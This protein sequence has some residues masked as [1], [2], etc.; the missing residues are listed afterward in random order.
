M[1]VVAVEVEHHRVAKQLD[2]KANHRLD[3]AVGPPIA[4]IKFAAFEELCENLRHRAANVLAGRRTGCR[5]RSDI[6][7]R[8]DP[9]LGGR[10]QDLGLIAGAV[11]FEPVRHGRRL[12]VFIRSAGI[13]PDQGKEVL[14]PARCRRSRH[15]RLSPP[16]HNHPSLLSAATPSP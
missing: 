16:L 8:D 12:R 13:L 5:C 15:D 11:L 3:I 7:C 10:P 4:V 2:E 9:L 6:G 1:Q 14:V